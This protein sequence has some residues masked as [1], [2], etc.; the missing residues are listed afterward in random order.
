MPTIIK[1]QVIDEAAF[2]SKAVLPS[3]IVQSDEDEPVNFSWIEEYELRTETHDFDL[4]QQE[5]TLRI[6]PISGKEKRSIQAIYNLINNKPNFDLLELRCEK[7]SIINR[8]WLALFLLQGNLDLLYKIEKLLQDKQVVYRRLLA[9]QAISFQ[10]VI[11]LET[12][13]TDISI[14][15]HDLKQEVKRVINQYGLESDSLFF[16]NFLTINRIESDIQKSM[17]IEDLKEPQLAYEKEMIQKEMEYEQSKS[18]RWIDFAQ[19]RYNGAPDDL[20]KERLHVGVGFR[21]PTSA[22]RK[23][24]LN[25]L[26]I[27]KISVENENELWIQER[28]QE[29]MIISGEITTAINNLNNY[30]QKVEHERNQLEELGDSYARQAGYDP[31]LLL[32]IEERHLKNQM[33]LLER[34]EDIYIDYLKWLFLDGRICSRDRLNFL[35]EN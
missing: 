24:K 15:I 25:E 19:L 5:V 13:L 32:E 31:V 34:K 8:D 3:A 29:F 12:D 30:I 17:V 20:F 35:S 7:L 21:F 18:K 4:K 1:S 6:S 14:S 22:D 26:A 23:L 11:E 33:I 16:Q 27:E 2:F 9:G 28:N 10:K